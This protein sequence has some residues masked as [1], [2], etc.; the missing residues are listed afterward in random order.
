MELFND[1]LKYILKSETR[2]H[3]LR[4][5]GPFAPSH[6]VAGF[7]SQNSVDY[8]SNCADNKIIWYLSC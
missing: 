6:F 5:C 1:V 4:V 3:D 8:R 2:L 7:F